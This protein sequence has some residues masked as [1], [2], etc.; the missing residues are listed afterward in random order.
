MILICWEDN[1]PQMYKKTAIRKKQKNC[2]PFIPQSAETLA[3]IDKEYFVSKVDI[4]DN[5]TIHLFRKL[6]VTPHCLYIPSLHAH[7][8][9]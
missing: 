8:Y 6:D 5:L 1:M 3:S 4:A 2:T 7:S 9:T